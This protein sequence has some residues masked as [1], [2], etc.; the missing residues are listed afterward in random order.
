MP[1]LHMIPSLSDNGLCE[2]A[3]QFE[4]NAVLTVA[5]LIGG[6]STGYRQLMNDAAHAALNAVRGY[7]MPQLADALACLEKLHRAN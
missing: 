3:C 5:S 7:H 4:G 1:K 2:L 6:A